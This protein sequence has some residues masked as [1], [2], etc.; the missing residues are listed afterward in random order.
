[1]VHFKKP[2]RKIVIIGAILTIVIAIAISIGTYQTRSSH[3][4]LER[5][6]PPFNAVLPAGQ[7]IDNL[8]GWQK[9][10]PPQGDP[11]F[12]F[13]DSISGVSINVSQQKLP[14]EFSVNPYQHIADLAK[15]YN[16]NTQIK[17]G[18]TVA[19]IGSSANGPQSVIFTK[20]SLLVLIKSW[21]ALSDG[22]WI[23]YIKNLELQR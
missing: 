19:Y 17:A 1:M 14:K 12:V 21:S 23:A 4:E 16:A 8:G 22:E 20:N 9:L 6:A 13:V 5:T 10:T 15:G 18:D 11:F 2:K 7:T 3:A